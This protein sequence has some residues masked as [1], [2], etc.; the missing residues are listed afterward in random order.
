MSVVQFPSS[1]N[2]PRYTNWV[3]CSSSVPSSLIF[4]S[5]CFCPVVIVFVFFTLIFY[6]VFLLLCCTLS[7]IYCKSAS[8]SAIRSISSANLK[9][10]TVCPFI[11]NLNS[12]ELVLGVSHINECDQLVKNMTDWRLEVDLGQLNDWWQLAMNVTDGGE[13]KA[14]LYCKICNQL[15]CSLLCLICIIFLV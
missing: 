10:L 5:A 2:L 13:L 9:L 14:T 15:C 6:P 3:T 1:V 7:V 8:V 11:Y 4:R 12:A